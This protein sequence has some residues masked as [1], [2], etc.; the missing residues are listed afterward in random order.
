MARRPYDKYLQYSRAKLMTHLMTFAL[1][2]RMQLRMGAQL[3]LTANV[4]DP[5]SVD[6]KL[7]R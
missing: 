6:H 5:G 4:V 1:H 7:T 3:T 2:R